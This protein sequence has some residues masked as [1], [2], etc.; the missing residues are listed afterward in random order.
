M[1]SISGKIIKIMEKMQ[2]N[3]ISKPLRKGPKRLKCK[4]GAKSLKEEKNKQENEIYRPLEK[5][6]KRLKRKERETSTKKKTKKVKE[7]DELQSIL[8]CIIQCLKEKETVVVIL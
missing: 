6:P 8:D 3:E 1:E 4:V 2:V 7:E 5:E